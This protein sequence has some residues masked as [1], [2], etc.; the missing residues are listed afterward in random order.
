ML[1]TSGCLYDDTA[2]DLLAHPEAA[3]L[4]YT[5]WANITARFAGKLDSVQ[6]TPEQ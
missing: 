3:N 2:A 5:H 4:K 6:L 1:A